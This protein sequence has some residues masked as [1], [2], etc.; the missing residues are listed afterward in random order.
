V[1]HVT[2]GGS[3]G[4]AV[5]QTFSLRVGG[6]W[7][8]T[9]LTGPS[10]PAPYAA[11]ALRVNAGYPAWQAFDGVE[12]PTGVTTCALLSG[13]VPNW[14][15]IDMGTP[16]IATRWRVATDGEPSRLAGQGLKDF[17]IR[18]SNTSATADL[19]TLATVTGWS[20]QPFDLTGTL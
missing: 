15:A 11:S 7:T 12:T 6:V 3:S 9:T 14:L 13:G 16:V 1:L 8:P 18:A 2:L 17:E 20:G 19:V 4:N 10:T 5:V